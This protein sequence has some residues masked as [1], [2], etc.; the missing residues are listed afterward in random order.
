MSPCH[1]IQSFLE[2]LKAVSIKITQYHKNKQRQKYEP[3]KFVK[4]FSSVV[5]DKGM[6]KFLKETLNLR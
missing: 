6:N 3:S 2:G 1:M 5:I 4:L